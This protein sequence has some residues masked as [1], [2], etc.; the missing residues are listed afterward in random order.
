MTAVLIPM[1]CWN[2]QVFPA[3][4]GCKQYDVQPEQNGFLL[5]AKIVL[6]SFLFGWFCWFCWLFCWSFFFT[7][8]DSNICILW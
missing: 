2:G 4:W 1:A 3:S 7:L 6:F 5:M 8:V